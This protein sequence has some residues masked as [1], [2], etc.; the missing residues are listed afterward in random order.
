[1]SFGLLWIGVIPHGWQTAQAGGLSG[2]YGLWGIKYMGGGAAYTA[3]YE[4][5]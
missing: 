2:A 5:W 3:A 1:M 4:Q